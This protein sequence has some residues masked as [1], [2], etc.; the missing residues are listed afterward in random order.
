MHPMVPNNKIFIDIRVLLLHPKKN[1]T[2]VCDVTSK[3]HM[4]IMESFDNIQF[5]LEMANANTAEATTAMY[6]NAVKPERPKNNLD[7][8]DTTIDNIT[9]MKLKTSEVGNL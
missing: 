5:D 3:T 7:G 4:T 8:I 1:G 6:A 2:K 9:P